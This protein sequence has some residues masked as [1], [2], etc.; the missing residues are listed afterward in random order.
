[1]SR[2]PVFGGTKTPFSKNTA[3][4]VECCKFSALKNSFLTLESGLSIRH[5]SIPPTKCRMVIWPKCMGSGPGLCVGGTYT[6]E[7]YYIAPSVA[8]KSQLTEADGWASAQEKL[9][10]MSRGLPWFWAVFVLQDQHLHV[11]SSFVHASFRGG[12]VARERELRE[13][14]F[15]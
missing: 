12:R 9:R 8:Q 11:E 10:C 2:P 14:F 15:V 1:M 4:S 13:T 5:Q 3:D 6:V 7:M